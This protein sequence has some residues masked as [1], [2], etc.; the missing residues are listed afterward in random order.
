MT[1]LS[2]L[3]NASVFFILNLSQKAEEENE[4]FNAP[5]EDFTVRKDSEFF[6]EETSFKVSERP[7]S[8][9]T[10]IYSV[11]ETDAFPT[12]PRLST[13]SSAYKPT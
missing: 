5:P 11:K 4:K 13:L 3:G 7:G 12:V 6:P 8:S 10:E 9:R 1:A 2:S